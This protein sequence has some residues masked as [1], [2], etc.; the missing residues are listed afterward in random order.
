MRAP[1]GVLFDVMPPAA[2]SPAPRVMVSPEISVQPSSSQ[3]PATRVISPTIGNS[4]PPAPATL[5]FADPLSQPFRWDAY[6]VDPTGGPSVFIDGAYHISQSKP[7]N[8]YYTLSVDQSFSNF[9]FEIEA[10]IIH[11]DRGGIIFR[12]DDTGTK[13]YLFQV[14]AS[15][16]Y[17][18]YV[19]VDNS[20]FKT[21]ASDTSPAITIGLN[22]TN[23]LAVVANRSTLDLY[24]N[25]TK[26]KSV[27]DNTYTS[28]Y[29]GLDV[30]AETNPTEV[31]FKNAK[32]WT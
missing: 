3:H 9:T 29:I 1:D 22:Q 28:G 25:H 4:Y 10:S 26:V 17:S 12:C 15:G 20:N 18:F 8:S 19:Q 13:Y 7:P 30:E 21:L 11:G 6:P 23:L 24:V 27:T 14:S 2:P 5:A 32:L 16:Y 31:A